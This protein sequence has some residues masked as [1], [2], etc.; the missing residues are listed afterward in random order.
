MDPQPET[1]EVDD[2]E[3]TNP[4]AEYEKYEMPEP[5]D[6][7]PEIK[8]SKFCFVKV[9]EDEA[10]WTFEGEGDFEITKLTYGEGKIL[11]AGEEFEFLGGYESSSYARFHRDGHLVVITGRQ[12]Y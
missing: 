1:F 7:F 10:E 12:D 6:I 3:I 4:L 2:E 5:E 11:Y 9:W 8:E